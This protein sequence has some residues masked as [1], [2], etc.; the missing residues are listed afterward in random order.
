VKTKK[1]QI[2]YRGKRVLDALI[3][4]WLTQGMTE[5]TDVVMSGTSAGGLTT[6]LHAEYF[7]T[8]LPASTK[9]FAVPDA[10]FF[11]DLPN[12]KGVFSWR[13]ELNGGFAAWNGTGNAPASCLAAYPNAT[14]QW[15]CHFPNYVLPHIT[16]VPYFV[17]NS[18]YD[19]FH[20]G[21]IL[22]L[23]C[24]PHAP[25]LAKEAADE[26]RQLDSRNFGVDTA[27]SSG[28]CTAAQ[29]QILQAYRD[30]FLATVS[31]ILKVQPTNGAG[32]TGCLQHEEICRDKD[33][34][35]IVSIV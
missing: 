14:E 5:A 28:V 12:T 33:F 7:R 20:I 16:S 25:T 29:L 15:H 32:L 34:M 11:L 2:Y 4:D 30:S 27:H 10:G 6:Y 8:R 22:Q 13:T 21:T 3:A 19:T 1:G 23:G 31:N 17:M 18:L 9:L 35:G 26:E 24:S